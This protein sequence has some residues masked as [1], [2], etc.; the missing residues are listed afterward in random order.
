MPSYLWQS[1]GMKEIIPTNGR[2]VQSTIDLEQ[3]EQK[4]ARFTFRDVVQFTIGALL[5]YTVTW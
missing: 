1:G 2:V 5:A 4:R 3:E